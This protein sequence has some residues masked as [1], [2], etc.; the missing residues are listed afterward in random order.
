[1]VAI[2]ELQ[3]ERERKRGGKEERELQRVGKR[4]IE[5]GRE[6]ERAEEKKNYFLLLLVLMALF[7][8]IKLHRRLST[9]TLP[10]PV[11]CDFTPYCEKCCDVSHENSFFSHKTCK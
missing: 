10:Y 3:T 5:R 7:Q 4:E 2:E 6:R 9:H 11:L 8:S 1:M